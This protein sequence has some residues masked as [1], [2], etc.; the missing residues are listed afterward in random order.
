LTAAGKAVARALQRYGAYVV[1]RSTGFAMFAEVGSPLAW[2]NDA[3][4]DL[5]AIRGLCRIVTNNSA[6]TPNG[7]AWTGDATNRLALLA[8]PLDVSEEDAMIGCKAFS[9]GGT[10]ANATTTAVSLS[11]KEWD[12]SG[13]FPA[14][15]GTRLT[16]PPGY[17]GRYTL[18]GCAVFAQ[19]AA[20]RR[21]ARIQINGGPAIARQDA[22]PVTTAGTTVGCTG[23]AILAVGDYLE[24]YVHQ[25][26]GAALPLATGYLQTS[27]NSPIVAYLSLRRIG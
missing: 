19:N 14:V 3:R 25:D 8:D 11:G 16:V 21:V 18:T 27:W 5:A 24:L 1:D 10:I 13:F 2:V 4:S 15:A 12:T 17:A 6:S 9:T 26:S 23:E 7:G 22:T 20:G